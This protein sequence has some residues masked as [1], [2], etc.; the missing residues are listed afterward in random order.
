MSRREVRVDAD[1]RN[2]CTDPRCLQETRKRLYNRTAVRDGVNTLD[3]AGGSVTIGEMGCIDISRRHTEYPCIVNPLATH[4][5]FCIPSAEKDGAPQ[6]R[7]CASDAVLS[8]TTP[9]N[10][11]VNVQLLLRVL[12]T[13][14]LSLMKRQK[15]KNHGE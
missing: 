8:E 12:H 13:C 3:T 4:S 7:K 11:F 15:R 9:Q 10:P 5:L 6:A 2:G 1:C 14:C